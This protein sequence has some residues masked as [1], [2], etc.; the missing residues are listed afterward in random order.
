MRVISNEALAAL[1]SKRFRA[2][3]LVKMIAGGG[4]DPLCFWD[5]AGPISYAGDIYIGQIGRFTI[6]PAASVSDLSVRNQTVTFSGLDSVIIG[7]IEGIQWHQQPIEI[8]RAIISVDNP[9]ILNITDDFVGFMDK[10][11][12]KEGTA[13]RPSTLAVTCEDASREYSLSGTRTASDADQR[14]R[15]PNDGF[16]SFAASATSTTIDW[17]QQPQTAPKQSSGGILGFLDKIF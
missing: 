12:W 15:D 9:Q 10:I 14:M 4:A 11:I 6:T 17:G 16:F 3:V 1:A 13:G 5:S 7:M 2:R 8:R